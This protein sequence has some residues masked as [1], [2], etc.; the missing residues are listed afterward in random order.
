[1]LHNFQ[2]WQSVAF[3]LKLR[4]PPAR[5]LVAS[6]AALRA[7]MGDDRSL[8]LPAR[9]RSRSVVR[10]VE[11]TLG[12]RSAAGSATQSPGS[13]RSRST[14]ARTGAAAPTPT[15]ARLRDDVSDEAE[16]EVAASEAASQAGSWAAS[17]SAAAAAANDDDAFADNV[18]PEFILPGPASSDE[19]FDWCL[20]GFITL[21]KKAGTDWGRQFA[22]FARLAAEAA[23]AA[24]PAAVPEP[25]PVVTSA[26]APA[27]VPEPMTTSATAMKKALKLVFG[28]MFSGIGTGEMAAGM[29]MHFAEETIG[30]HL[31]SSTYAACDIDNVCQG[32]LVSHQGKHAPQHV[33]GSVLDRIP[34]YKLRAIESLQKQTMDAFR[35][36]AS[37][38][39]WSKSIKNREFV[40]RSKGF[41]RAAVAILNDISDGSQL[42]DRKT[43]AF[44]SKHNRPCCIGPGGDGAHGA[45]A[46]FFWIDMAGLICTPW[47]VQGNQHMWLDPNSLPTIVY[48]WS[49]RRMMPDQV[50]AECTPKLDIEMVREVLGP[51]FKVENLVF[52]VSLFGYPANRRRVYMR[53]T[54]TKTVEHSMPFTHYNF[55]RIFR[56][57]HVA[58]A[59]QLFFRASQ[60]DITDFMNDI[61]G[62]RGI[63]PHPRGKLYQC[64]HVLQIAQQKRLE[65]YELE[66]KRNRQQNVQKGTPLDEDTTYLAHIS[67]NTTHAPKAA[68]FVPTLLR[69]S[70]VWSE[71]LQ[72]TMLPA[73]HFLVQG[74]PWCHYYHI[75][76][77][78]SPVK[79]L[80]TSRYD[81]D[82]LE[83]ADRGPAEL[84]MMG[85]STIRGLCGNAMALP[86]IGSVL[87][88]TFSTMQ[89]KMRPVVPAAVRG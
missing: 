11:R 88:Y 41:V 67:Q 57:S 62:R 27:A 70:V 87:L 20:D 53:I 69:N 59:E 84:E 86:S 9:L 58:T 76:F 21:E 2:T 48:L 43:L 80:F 39:G 6:F 13:S 32:I 44:C 52:D 46:D 79:W 25:E 31:D 10:S 83:S 73:E 89:V 54:N 7:V 1:M 82:R 5:D 23:A 77:Q 37:T 78:L 12:R 4:V 81:R 74:L 51:D 68:V 45:E 33:F 56:R 42:L 75:A 30:D 19:L 17:A 24:A 26:S 60:A 38:S 66:W 29:N 15:G 8:R 85:S 49:V 34:P 3:W 71:K 65:D 40:T 63:P 64:R 47:S 16:S 14:A 22:P 72:R 28:S 50:L 55:Q 35:A 18:L 61:A 36:E